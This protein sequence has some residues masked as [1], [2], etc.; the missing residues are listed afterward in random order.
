MTR[1]YFER[2]GGFAG[3]RLSTDVDSQSLDED[4][5]LWL[6][7]EIDQGWFFCSSPAHPVSWGR[8]GSL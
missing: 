3:L 4:E 7:Q 6:E 8:C 2:T 5:S 1:I